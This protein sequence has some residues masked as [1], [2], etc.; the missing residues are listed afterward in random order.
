MK[1]SDS[2]K[3]KVLSLVCL[4]LLN[5]ILFFVCFR[6]F[7]RIINV[8]VYFTGL[9]TLFLCTIFFIVV[10]IFMIY[11]IS[12]KFRHFKRVGLRLDEVLDMALSIQYRLV[13]AFSL[14]DL[15]LFCAYYNH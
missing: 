8:F 4:M 15:I 13:L 7:V 14:I 6:L 10:I 5:M 9:V 11:R 2:R 3:I 12:I 1:I